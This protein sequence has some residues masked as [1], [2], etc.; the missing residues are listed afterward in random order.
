MFK[1]H[2]LG[3]R[4]RS[5]PVRNVVNKSGPAIEIILIQDLPSD[6]FRIGK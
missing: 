2:M 6:L 3:F 1:G 4:I 5:L